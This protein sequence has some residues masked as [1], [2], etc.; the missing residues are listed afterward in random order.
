MDLLIKKGLFDAID[1]ASDM[2]GISNYEIVDFPK[3]ESPIDAINEIFAADHKFRNQSEWSGLSKN[4][5][6]N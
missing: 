2:A 4:L 1:Y 3:V 6:Q 5:N